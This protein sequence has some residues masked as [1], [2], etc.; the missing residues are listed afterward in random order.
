MDNTEPHFLGDYR[1]NVPQIEPDRNSPYNI[2]VNASPLGIITAERELY[3][4]IRRFNCFPPNRKNP[5]ILVAPEGMFGKR[6]GKK[7]ERMLD[8]F[9]AAREAIT[10]WLGKG[11]ASQLDWD[12]RQGLLEG[13]RRVCDLAGNATFIAPLPGVSGVWALHLDP[14]GMRRHDELWHQEVAAATAASRARV[15]EGK[16]RAYWAIRRQKEKEWA[17]RSAGHRKGPTVWLD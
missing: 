16:R 5:L 1:D 2:S 10:D 11:F 3:S 8:R 15:I 17:S 12:S 4:L 6:Q 14:V 13:Y 9:L 7:L